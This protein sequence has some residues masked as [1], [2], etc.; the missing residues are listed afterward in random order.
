[1]PYDFQYLRERGVPA[2]AASRIAGGGTIDSPAV[3]QAPDTLAGAPA[4]NYAGAYGGIPQVPSPTATAG[5]AVAGNLT[6]L[7][8]IS[9]LATQTTALGNT[10]A[11]SGYEANLPGY[12]SMLGQASAN[13]GNLLSGILPPDVIRQIQQAGAERGVAIGSPGSPNANAAMLRALGLTSLNLQGQGLGQ[14]GQLMGMTPVAQPFN[15]ASMMVS[16]GDLQ[17]AQAAANLYNAAPIPW[18]AAQANLNAML[19][20]LNRGQATTG[21]GNFGG[22]MPSAPTAPGS[23]VP[24]YPGMQSQPTA[25]GATGGWG[26]L[27]QSQADP[28]LDEILTR[29]GENPAGM[30]WEDKAY[31]ADLYS[32]PQSEP[33]ARV[34][35]TEASYPQLSDFYDE[36]Y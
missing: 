13:T 36:E 19:S 1:M 7:P 6:N 5:N 3:T 33:Y 14:F 17:S 22:Y 25:P 23:K 29:Y 27:T 20:G 8:N 26:S 2:A 28:F 24:S 18:Q 32:M 31:W 12:N 10:L 4:F 16:P 11:K 21:P 15:P 34:S 30:S 9:N 35:D